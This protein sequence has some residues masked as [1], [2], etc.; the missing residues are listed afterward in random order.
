MSSFLEGS[1]GAGAERLR[2][3]L[4]TPLGVGAALLAACERQLA[5]EREAAEADVQALRSVG[6]QMTKYRE[7]MEADSEL[8][9]S[10]IVAL[11]S[12]LRPISKHPHGRGTA[13]LANPL[14]TSL[15]PYALAV[16]VCSVLQ[17]PV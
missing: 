7:A 8:Q 4:D 16:R 12:G 11:V 15:H 9:L 2:L 13:P 1:T 14:G 17:W 10:R 5:E 3:K 6:P